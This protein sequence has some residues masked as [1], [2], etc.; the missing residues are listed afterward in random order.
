MKLSINE[1]RRILEYAE[2]KDLD[3]ELSFDYDNEYQCITIFLN[4]Y[5]W[6]KFV[7]IVK[8]KD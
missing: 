5:A 3:D 1:L 4:E 6:K 2:E 7:E 8:T